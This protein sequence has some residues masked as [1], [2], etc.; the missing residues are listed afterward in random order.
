MFKIYKLEHF[1]IKSYF[2]ILKED[3]KDNLRAGGWW[4]IRAWRHLAGRSFTD[5][6][7]LTIWTTLN[8]EEEKNIKHEEFVLNSFLSIHSHVDLG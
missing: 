6:V 2:K 1:A 3:L 7:W 8:P 5:Q 4:V